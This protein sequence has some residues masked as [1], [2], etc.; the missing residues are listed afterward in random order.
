MKNEY[1]Q[2]AQITHSVTFGNLWH[3]ASGKRD[4]AAKRTEQLSTAGY[5]TQDSQ[6]LKEC[7]I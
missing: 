7:D 6:I 4:M 1:P 5:E 2:I 3:L